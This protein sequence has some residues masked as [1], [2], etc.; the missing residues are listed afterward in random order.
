MKRAVFIEQFRAGPQ[1]FRGL[2]FWAWCS[3]LNTSTTAETSTEHYVIKP[4]NCSVPFDMTCSETVSIFDIVVRAVFRL[5]RRWTAVSFFPHPSPNEA[6]MTYIVLFMISECSQ[7]QNWPDEPRFLPWTHL[8]VSGLVFMRALNMQTAPGQYNDGVQHQ[9]VRLCHGNFL[10]I[11][12]RK[13]RWQW[14]GCLW[15]QTQPRKHT[16]ISHPSTNPSTHP[17]YYRL[18]FRNYFTENNIRH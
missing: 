11:N 14:L 1:S 16:F 18:D 12:T 8:R 5:Q 15:T 13:C 3:D 7:G 17:T 6:V 2:I 9:F 4:V 10:C